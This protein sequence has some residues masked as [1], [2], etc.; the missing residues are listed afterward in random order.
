M[1]LIGTSSWEF[2]GTWRKTGPRVEDM[3]GESGVGRP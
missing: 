2:H 1:G 3:S